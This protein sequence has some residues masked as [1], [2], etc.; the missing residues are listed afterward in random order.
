M[1]RHDLIMDEER[2]ISNPVI[3]IVPA[4]GAHIAVLKK[5]LRQEDADEILRF[6]FTVQ[7]AIW[8]TYRRSLVRKTALIDGVVAACWGISGTF[9]G[10]T[11]R[12][13][14]MTTPEVK[15]V[16]P[17]KFARIYQEEMLKMLAMFPRLE[18]MVDAKYASAIRLLEIIGFNVDEPEPV[19]SGGAL[20]R[21]FWIERA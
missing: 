3:S 2:T 15:K 16:S 21:K 20:Y 6:G 14:L 5:N 12:P 9:M 11:G 17:L 4:T 7:H 19:G 18:N 10:Q 13:W 8:L 1:A